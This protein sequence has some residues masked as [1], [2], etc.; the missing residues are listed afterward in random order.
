MTGDH[1]TGDHMTGDPASVG[2][3]HYDTTDE[4]WELV[5]EDDDRSQHLVHWNWWSIAMIHGIGGQT[6]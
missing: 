5:V 1:M 2:S 4:P 6:R 3:S